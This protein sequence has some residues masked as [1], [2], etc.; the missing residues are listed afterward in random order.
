MKRLWPGRL[1]CALTAGLFVYM[2]AVEVPAIS[3]LL[4][5]M[6][7]PDQLPLG[8]NEAGARALH[9]AFSND[10]A[11]AQEQERQSAASA[12]QALHAGSDLI[13]P[14]LLTASLGFCAFAALYARGKHAETPLMVRVGLGLV[15]ALAF[16]Y[17]GCDFVENAV[18]DAIFGPNALRVAFNEQLVFVLRVLTISKFTSVAIAFGLIAALWISCW[19]SRSEQ[20]AADG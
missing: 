18:A 3:A 6:K 19:R 9:T 10:L 1:L 13:F 17:L 20:P 15:L 14:P 12:Y 8:Y 11:V 7:L 16:T 4:G 2:A 5:G